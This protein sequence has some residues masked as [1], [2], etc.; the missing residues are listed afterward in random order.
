M[1]IMQDAD[2]APTKQA[3]DAIADLETSIPALLEKWSAV[4]TQD[5][6]ATNTILRNAKLPELKP[7]QKTKAEQEMP[8]NEE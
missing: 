2:V 3:I 5:V 1:G 6:S 4:K 7:D 8:G